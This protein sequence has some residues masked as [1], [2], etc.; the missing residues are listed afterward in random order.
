[1]LHNFD[2]PTIQVTNLVKYILDIDTQTVSD[3]QTCIAC[4]QVTIMM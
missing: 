3:T 2:C 1:M 4:I